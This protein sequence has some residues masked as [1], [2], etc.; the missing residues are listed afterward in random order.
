MSTNELNFDK[1]NQMLQTERNC[2]NFDGSRRFNVNYKS[3]SHDDKCF[4][5]I[6]T[7]QSIGPGNYAV[8]NL[9]DCE[10]MMPQTVKS[11]TDNVAVPVGRNGY[12]TE[13]SCVVDDGS[14]LRWGLTKKYPKCPQQL[15]ERPYKTVA[16]M[17][18]GYLRPDEETILIQGEQVSTKRSCGALSGITIPNYF[19]PLLDHLSYNVQNPVHIIEEVGSNGAIRHGG[20]NSRLAVRD[21]DMLQR[22]GKNYQYSY[23]NKTTNPEFWK[24]KGML[25]QNQ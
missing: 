17:G 18:R 22:C 1:N 5:D 11:A 6:D 15:F 14:K 24:D 16:Y 13:Q 8:S 21:Y 4:I 23:M 10:C 2:I 19:T 12:G 25:L 3:M 20:W 9:Y 7:R